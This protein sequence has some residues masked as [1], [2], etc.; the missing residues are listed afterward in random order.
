MIPFTKL[1]TGRVLLSF[2]IPSFVPFPLPF[3]NIGSQNNIAFI[4]VSRGS[5]V[6]LKW[7]RSFLD[8]P[9]FN[10]SVSSS[11]NITGVYFC[12]ANLRKAFSVFLFREFL[13]SS[14]RKALVLIWGLTMFVVIVPGYWT[15]LWGLP[16]S[17]M[18]SS[19][20]SVS[21][22]LRLFLLLV[23]W[24]IMPGSPVWISRRVIVF[25]PLLAW[26][27]FGCLSIFS[28]IAIFKIPVVT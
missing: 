21:K 23:R 16:A 7:F 20:C 8:L 17:M 25:K 26:R 9:I 28:A 24:R 15:G 19:I 22:V 13:S 27:Y 2:D 5:I 10:L 3:A 4:W 14:I 1:V 12:K 18:M 6:I 11:I